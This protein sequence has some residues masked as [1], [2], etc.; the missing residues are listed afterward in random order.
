MSVPAKSFGQGPHFTGL[1][2]PYNATVGNADRGRHVRRHGV[3]PDIDASPG[4]DARA[5]RERELTGEIDRSRGHLRGDGGHELDFRAL[6]SA[7]EHRRDAALAQPL[8]EPDPPFDVPHLVVE[9]RMHVQCGVG[10]PGSRPD[11]SEATREASSAL[12]RMSMSCRRAIPSASVN[13]R[14]IATV[15]VSTLSKATERDRNQYFQPAVLPGHDESRAP[16]AGE[17]RVERGPVARHARERDVV[18]VGTER[19]RKRMCSIDARPLGNG[20]HTPHV[21]MRRE[22]VLRAFEHEHVDRGLRPCRPDRSNE[23]GGE[24]HVTHPPGDDQR[25]RSRASPR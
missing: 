5:L 10:L 13:A 20:K 8:R 16:A 1:D 18:A 22:H 7:G 14:F 19:K 3:G 17:D 6:A 15:W 9:L 11:S 21:G 24:Q 12:Q 2:G 23:R 4:N 25:A